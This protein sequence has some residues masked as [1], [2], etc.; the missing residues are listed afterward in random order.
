MWFLL[1]IPFLSDAGVEVFSGL[2]L[3]LFSAAL[4]VSQIMIVVAAWSLRRARIW[5]LWGLVGSMLLLP[6][7]ATDISFRCRLW[8]SEVSLRQY[9]VDMPQDQVGRIDGGHA[10]LFHF[11]YVTRGRDGVV[12]FYTGVAFKSHYGFAYVPPNVSP[13]DD[14]MQHQFGPWYKIP[15]SG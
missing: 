2:L 7:W 5:A 14:D 15:G 8:L 13:P 12:Y 3:L 10:G 11:E 4:G 9:V 1:T 6:N